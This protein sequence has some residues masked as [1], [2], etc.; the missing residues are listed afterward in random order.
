MN[1]AW[2]EYPPLEGIAIALSGVAIAVLIFIAALAQG[3]FLWWQ[4][5]TRSPFLQMLTWAWCGLLGYALLLPW[6]ERPVFGGLFSRWNLNSILLALV[7]AAT[8]LGFAVG[9]VLALRTHRTPPP[10][11][12]TSSGG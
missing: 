11:R 1:P 4:F 10:T 3:W 9:A 6:I 7:I 5:R 12:P 2:Q 8:Y